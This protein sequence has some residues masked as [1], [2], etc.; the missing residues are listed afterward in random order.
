MQGKDAAAHG[1]TA[2]LDLRITNLDGLIK[3]LQGMP[4]GAEA[5]AG[6]SM[7]QVMG[8]KATT[9]DGRPARDYDIVVDDAGKILVTAAPTWPR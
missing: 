9:A 1:V 8:R 7:A 6:P 3:F 4:D 2:D 5:A